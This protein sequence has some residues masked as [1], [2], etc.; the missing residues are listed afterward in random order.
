[1]F[2]CSELETRTPI[3]T[4]PVIKGMSR[5]TF[6][7]ILASAVLCC[8]GCGLGGDETSGYK[9]YPV[10]G[11]IT[12]N[13]QPVEGA[14]VTFLPESGNA[15]NTPG[16]DLSGPMG[17]YMAMYRGRTGLAVGKYKV[18]V[19]KLVV[20]KNTAA[21]PDE[22]KADLE[23]ATLAG[24]QAPGQARGAAKAAPKLIEGTYDCE[25]TTSATDNQFDFD[26]KATSAVAKT[27]AKL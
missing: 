15:P 17:N 16:G 7:A 25:V 21:L 22:I 1:M 13:S 24:G 4:L 10:K 19:K 3:R 27:A 6:R 9:L 18:V 2:F 11:T 20:P 5:L 8:A 12:L 14:E 23:M 26:L